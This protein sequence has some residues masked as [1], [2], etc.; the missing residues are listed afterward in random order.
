MSELHTIAP[1][2]LS[3][4]FFQRLHRQWA[5]ITA[6]DGDGANTMTASWGG[7]GIL[8][9]K[10]VATVYVRPSRYTFGLIEREAGFSLSFLPEQYRQELSYCGKISG[11]DEDKIAHCG[12]TVLRQE[13]V[14]YIA[15]AELV[16]LCRKLYSQDMDPARF[17]DPEIDPKN[18]PDGDYHR[19]YIGEITGAL[20][21]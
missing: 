21:R 4:N 2:A 12:F 7:V 10:P 18:Y 9:N 16:L 14:P 19:I 1:M 5:L 15:Q 11:R 3:E 20:G 13:G 8:W 6:A 17:L